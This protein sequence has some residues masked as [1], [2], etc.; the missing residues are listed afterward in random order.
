MSFSDSAASAILDLRRSRGGW[1]RLRTPDV[2]AP[3]WR[4]EDGTRQSYG[5]LRCDLDPAGA[6]DLRIAHLEAIDRI[7]AAALTASESNDRREARRLAAAA[8]RL[9]GEIVGR[10][11]PSA[12]EVPRRAYRAEGR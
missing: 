12:V 4:E 1:T 9:C 8:S 7:A 6:S 3:F 5:V 10:W 2:E 11:S